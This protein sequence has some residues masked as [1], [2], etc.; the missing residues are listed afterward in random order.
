MELERT[1]SIYFGD[2]KLWEISE[3]LL[4][5]NVGHTIKMCSIRRDVGVEDVTTCKLEDFYLF[6]HTWQYR[7]IKKYWASEYMLNWMFPTSIR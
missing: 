6:L 5:D 2:H 3:R 4:K 7:E 1:P